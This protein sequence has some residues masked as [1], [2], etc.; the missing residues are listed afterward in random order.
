MFEFTR[1][2]NPAKKPLGTKTDVRQYLNQEKTIFN[3]KKRVQL[4]VTTFYH[5]RISAALF[6]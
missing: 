5:I 6:C 2:F 1:N 4:N 3:F